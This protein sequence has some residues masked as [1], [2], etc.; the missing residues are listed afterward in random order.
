M[1]NFV[2]FR[3]LFFIYLVVDSFAILVGWLRISLALFHMHCVAIWKYHFFYHALNL[4]V[5]S[6]SIPS[7]LN[8]HE[9]WLYYSSLFHPYSHLTDVVEE[10]LYSV[11]S[12]IIDI[13]IEIVIG[14]ASLGEDNVVVLINK[15][16]ENPKL[17][18]YLWRSQD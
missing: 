8:E 16:L 17:A 18:D 4:L 9:M 10:L 15:T 12:T 14:I 11:R 5:V 3:I 13:I 6:L 7:L 1:L 2:D